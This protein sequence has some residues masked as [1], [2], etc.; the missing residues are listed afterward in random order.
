MSTNSRFI[1]PGLVS[2]LI[3]SLYFPL[4]LGQFLAS[5]LTTQQQ[6]IALF[7]NFT[8]MSDDLTPQQ[9]Q[10]VSYWT[11]DYANIFVN[12]GIFM[13]FTVSSKMFFEKAL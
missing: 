6:I 9:A 10:I 8:W 3:A 1:Y 4:G 12:L 2:L 7:S 13:I 11:N 5:E